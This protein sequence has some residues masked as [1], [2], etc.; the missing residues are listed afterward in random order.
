MLFSLLHKPQSFFFCSDLPV[1]AMTSVLVALNRNHH[2]NKLK[3]SGARSWS[4]KKSTVA[5]DRKWEAK[6]SDMLFTHSNTHMSYLC[7]PF[8]PRYDFILFLLSLRMS[9]CRMTGCPV[10]LSCTLKTYC[11]WESASKTSLNARTVVCLGRTAP[12][13]FP[14]D[15]V[16]HYYPGQL[17]N[18]R[19]ATSKIHF[20]FDFVSSSQWQ[21]QGHLLPWNLAASK[22]SEAEEKRQKL[23]A[24]DLALTW[25]NHW[26]GIS[27]M[28]NMVVE[29]SRKTA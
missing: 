27:W 21:S 17:S 19:S 16:E 28:M 18:A 10:F 8:G 7:R 14:K 22:S 5:V 2:Q 26:I 15:T 3:V 11:F 9:P 29:K 13:R 4:K 25:E 6:Q 23:E 12:V 1:R 20:P 24:A